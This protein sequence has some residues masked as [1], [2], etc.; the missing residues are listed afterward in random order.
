MTELLI[1]IP[2]CKV[3]SLSQSPPL[4]AGPIRWVGMR[5]GGKGV[6]VNYWVQWIGRAPRPIL[7]E[8]FSQPVLA[9]GF[10]NRFSTRGRPTL[11]S[12]SEMWYAQFL[13]STLAFLLVTHPAIPVHL[14]F[15]VPSQNLLS[16]LPPLSPLV[17]SMCFS[18]FAGE[19][20]PL[21]LF[22]KQ[23]NCWVPPPTYRIRNFKESV[24]AMW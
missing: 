24:S 12:C 18:T 14:T 6:Y 21:G 8:I 22:I 9:A 5:C 23:M 10:P 19:K 17:L 7:C 11:A 15:K 2:C 1:S 3:L 13:G 20:S 4:L 16:S